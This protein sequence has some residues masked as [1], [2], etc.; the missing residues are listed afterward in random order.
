MASLGQL[1]NNKDSGLTTKKTFMVPLAEIYAEEGYNVRELNIPHVEEFRDA[2]ISG[3][4][5]PPLAV[6]V[7]ERGVKVIDGHHRYYGALA[8][9]E[10]G[11]EI[12]RL[13]CKDFVGTEADKIAFMITSS[14]GLALT[15]LER[16][17]AY[18]RLQN[19]GFS[20][21]EIA[22]KVKRSESDVLQHIQ[23]NECSP[24]LKS[25]VRSG[26]LNYA[27]AI[28]ISREHGVYADREAARLMKKAEDAG[29][30]KITKSIA[31][32]QFNAAKARRVLELLCDA[33]FSNTNGE[34]LI[35]TDGTSEEI[36]R[37]LTEY[38]QGIQTDPALTSGEQ[39]PCQTTDE[40]SEEC[41]PVLKMDLINKSVQ[42]WACAAAAFGDKEEFTFFESK[43][44]HSWLADSFEHPTI[45]VVMPE[46][47]LK[48]KH[49]ME[50]Y[51]DSKELRSWL[52]SSVCAA[53]EIDHVHERMI[54][55]ANEA[56]GDDKSPIKNMADFISLMKGTPTDTWFNIRK[57]RAAVFASI[58]TEVK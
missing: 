34:C 43:F 38:R 6:E 25:L 5:L 52:E 9:V 1:Y 27:L 53:E 29:K 22:K 33:E 39:Q 45:V 19:Q 49:L 24:Y 44:A 11:H 31:K 7:T 41:L 10:M 55:V 30:T 47:I 17:I 46:I 57:L 20:N 4:Y 21:A 28:N 18:M 51:L 23:L 8:A 32:P 3:E 36:N 13:E 12:V 48:A 50:K 58:D 16:G 54:D 37:I 14:Q 42:L 26:S 2:F 15:P 40:S 56:M 35:L